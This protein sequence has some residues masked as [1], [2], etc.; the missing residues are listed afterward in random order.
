MAL[1]QK[2]VGEGRWNIAVNFES[3]NDT[4]FEKI[5][6]IPQAVNQMLDWYLEK[7]EDFRSEEKLNLGNIAAISEPLV[8]IARDITAILKNFS[9]DPFVISDKSSEEQKALWKEIEALIEGKIKNFH[10]ELLSYL[11]WF[12]GEEEVTTWELGTR[13]PVGKYAPPPPRRNSSFD[14]KGKPDRGSSRGQSSDRPRG[15]PRNKNPRGK[16]D[17]R[18]ERNSQDIVN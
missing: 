10:G 13:P 7:F 15:R 4:A 5:A 8:Y 9:K 2:L 17:S 3:D 1:P 14:R 16:G 6:D 12:Y 11:K 18:P